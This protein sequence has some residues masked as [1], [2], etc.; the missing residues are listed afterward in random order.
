MKIGMIFPGQGSQFL[1]MGK[2]FYDDERIVQEHFEQASKCL[3]QN[4]VRLCFASSE[5]E[6]CETINAQT[7]IFLISASIYSILNEKYGIV[8]D[9]VAGHSSGEYSAIYAAKGITFPD[10]LYLLKKRSLFMD[11]ATKSQNGGMLAVIGLSENN[12]RE[13]CSKYDDVSGVERVAQIV[14][15]N[16]SKQFVIS[17]TFPELEKIKLD[18]KSAKGKA[19]PLNVA[20]AFHSRLM[21]EPA[22]KFDDYMLKVDFKDLLIP[23]VNNVQAKVILNHDQV[24]T[25]LVKQLSAPILWWQSMKEFKDCDIIIQLGPLDKLAK[26]LQREWPDKK[27]VSINIPEDIKNLLTFLGREKDFEEVKQESLEVDEI[28]EEVA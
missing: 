26:M 27:I 16:S 7:A 11:E 8:P 15:F 22:K 3:D 19:I 25:S 17:G 21:L 18:V 13:I 1:G 6:L 10:A 12:L 24:K 4:F 20:G 5:K 9:I 2:E 23:F 28:T 14:N